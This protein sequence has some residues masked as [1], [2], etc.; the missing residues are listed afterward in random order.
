MDQKLVTG[1]G[2]ESLRGGGTLVI[3]MVSDSE[4]A[5]ELR[6]AKRIKKKMRSI[7]LPF[8]PGLPARVAAALL[9]LLA[10]LS[11]AAQEPPA[12]PSSR[13]AF[14][15]S[16]DLPDAR[17]GAQ[18]LAAEYHPA[19]G[20]GPVIWL[21][22]VAHIGSAEYYRALQ[23][24]LDGCTVVLFEGVDGADMKRVRPASHEADL[25]G[26]IARSL[27]LVY[28]LEAIDY[29]RPHFHNG[30]LSSE[31][32]REE[33]RAGTADDAPSEA[34]EKT[35]DSLVGALRGQPLGGPALNGGAIDVGAAA[36]QFLK[37]ASGSEQSREFTRAI[38][39]EAMGQAGELLD[40]AAKASPEMKALLELLLT[41]RNDA[42]LRHLRAR[43]PR[44]EPTENI[45]IFYGAAHMDGIERTL[46]EELRYVRASEH[47]ETAF[48]A[49]P[50]KHG[51]QPQF[52][53]MMLEMAKVQAGA[54]PA[55]VKASPDEAAQPVQ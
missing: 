55:P 34:V 36:D 44:L 12:A 43:L 7:P 50:A 30:D 26:K 39:V 52:L 25:Q 15:R 16:A 38:L 14:I 48:T 28:Q 20:G 53:R 41:K 47:W 32:L 45:A 31:E 11:L 46:R 21:I 6:I 51:I 4:S 27:G 23:Q 37:L 10:P 17:T 22:G 35:F 18:T 42:L 19:N 13:L 1:R 29:R 8:P 5:R 2:A 33:I 9:C 24:R 54:L 40:V 3:F 49:E